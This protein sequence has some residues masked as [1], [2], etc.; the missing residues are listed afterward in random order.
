MRRLLSVRMSIPALGESKPNEET[1]IA[2]PLSHS[3]VCQ[4]T[5]KR[6]Y[7]FSFQNIGSSRSSL[8]QIVQVN[9]PTSGTAAPFSQLAGVWVQYP[10]YVMPVKAPGWWLQDG[11]VAL[12][13]QFKA[14]KYCHASMKAH[15]ISYR[16]QF[17]TGTNAVSFANSN[18]QMHSYL[19]DGSV[20]KLPP[21]NIWDSGHVPGSAVPTTNSYIDTFLHG[22]T[23]IEP[24][25]T[26]TPIIGGAETSFQTYS[27]I[28][29]FIEGY[30]PITPGTSTI[31]PLGMSYS[32]GY[33]TFIKG[34]EIYGKKVKEW[35]RTYN[36]KSYWGDR[37][38][39]LAGHHM[40][41]ATDDLTN[42]SVGAQMGTAWN[43]GTMCARPSLTNVD[44]IT[45]FKSTHVCPVRPSVYVQPTL[46]VDGAYSVG[47]PEA[48]DPGQMTYGQVSL[49]KHMNVMQ[50]LLFGVESLPNQDATIVPVVV[51]MYMDTEIQIECTFGHGHIMQIAD[52]NYTTATAVQPAITVCQPS[53]Y[54]TDWDADEGTYYGDWTAVLQDPNTNL[55]TGQLNGFGS[56]GILGYGGLANT[57][58][59]YQGIGA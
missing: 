11:E 53:N 47:L 49:L 59:Q 29:W 24:A 54:Q 35:N 57:G 45:I 22:N 42:Q 2:R 30:A 28:P 25:T 52:T 51:D 18:M 1:T 4:F 44:P 56:M 33:Q 9:Q 36:L 19:Y 23:S 41:V 50:N 6:R 37:W 40:P 3:N 21:Y 16:T 46:N 7:M 5:F 14:F 12:I 55:G 27:M 39:P 43:A 26:S 10:F 13:L 15:N 17:T 38:L 58:C 20:A 48:T 32:Q 34:S 31:N 8:H